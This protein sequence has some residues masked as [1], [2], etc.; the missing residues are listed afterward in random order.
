MATALRDER[1]LSVRLRDEITAL[2]DRGR[3]QPGD[4]L[5]TEAELTERFRISRPAL[6]EALKLLE[7]EGM[8]SVVHGRGR[9]VSAAAAVRVK[10]PITYFESATDMVRHF[11]YTPENKV[12]DLS[13]TGADQ[14]TAA[15]LGIPKGAPVV[16][17]ERLRVQ[18]GSAIIYSVDLVP[19][20][21]LPA[22]LTALDW[23]G[24]LCDL[25]DRCGH[26]PRASAATASAGLLPQD[27]IDLHSLADFGPAFLIS[28]ICY[29]ASGR[30]VL[31]A[32]DYHRGSAFS[33]SFARK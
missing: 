23:G 8:V 3:L 17:L 29:S 24:S 13:E 18:G 15:A 11:G 26:R 25:L 12:L 1:A 30:P 28:E 20:P 7:Q 16:R 6:R 14:E 5:P 2:I 19:R 21:V 33:F 27:V 31:Y 32:H 22:D 9:F 4:K 10:R